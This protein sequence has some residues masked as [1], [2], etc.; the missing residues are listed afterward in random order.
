MKKLVSF[1]FILASFIGWASNPDKKN[2]YDGVYCSGKGDADFLRLID[3]SYASFYPNPTIPNVSMIYN[4]EWDTFTEG[5]SWGAWWVQNSYG[6]SYSVIP[7]L[8]E[9]WFSTLQRSWDLFWTNQGDGIRKG[10][11]TTDGKPSK[12]S[13]LIAPDGSLGDCAAPGKIIYKQGDGNLKV[14]DWFY[15]ATAA[16]IVVQAEI[17]LASHDIQ[18]AMLYLP[19]MERACD[20]IE[21]T[22]DPKNNLFLVGAACNLLAPSYAGVKLPDGTWG[23]A[24][25]S[26]LSITYLAALDR[27]IELL[28][29]T[30]NQDKIKEYRH[31]QKITRE[32]LSQLITPEGY[33]VK[34]VEPDG[35][36]HGV[37]GEKKYGYLEGVA[38]ADAVALRV[39][40][41]KLSESIYNKIA[42]FKEIR[43]FDFLLTNAPGLDDT[44]YSW[45]DANG[46][47]LKGIWK[48]GEWVNGGVWATVEA[49]AILMYYRLGKFEDVR[50]SAIRNMKWSKDFRMDAPWSQRGENT[51]NIWSDAGRNQENG[52]AVMVDNFAI[53]AAT[54]RG[55]FD[56]EYRSDQLIIRPRVP[57]SIKE[58]VQKR[59]V[60]FGTKKIYLSCLNNGP[61]IES[62][63]INSK[64]L[65]INSS[66][67]INLIYENL[68]AE[69][70]VEILTSGEWPAE[71]ATADYPQI[72]ALELAGT[73]ADVYSLPE[74]L[75]KPYKLLTAMMTYLE[76]D[77]YG[78]FD[79]A[80]VAAALESINDCIKRQAIDSGAGYY[81]PITASRKEGILKFYE[82]T[83][84]S[85]Y[86]GFEHRMLVYAQS[87][88]DHEKHLAE[89]FNQ[90]K[91]KNEN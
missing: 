61:K 81:R 21:R 4:P 85:M 5:A 28:K 12:H 25:L 66:N 87:P 64:A 40:D 79:K 2:N 7:I 9:P 22:R 18:K 38:N 23:K 31:R 11:F 20:C 63:K 60:R 50:R 49:R 39:S 30:G 32:S 82:K 57:Q 73:V 43:P 76:K 83:A 37:L 16:G 29:F 69:A 65:K 84:L 62:V 80:F 55:I 77:Q 45:G 86:A 78:S 6:F 48:F 56:Y 52:V 67:E 10:G 51:N 91:K 19:K 58:Y 34:Y 59:P 15:E 88:D 75:K 24:Y 68:P 71:P 72:P 17:L 1:L 3:E 13:E 46:I 70:R 42:S 33:F 44:Y 27:M 74:T 89:T 36:R 41:P 47:G 90:L 8:E 53:P 26:G 14:H 54:I 35:T